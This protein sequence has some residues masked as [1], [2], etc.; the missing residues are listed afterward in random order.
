MANKECQAVREAR[1]TSQGAAPESREQS[2]LS[3][4]RAFV[5]QFR[6]E[7][8]TVHGGFVGR[9]EHMVSGHAARFHSPEELVAFIKRI[10]ATVRE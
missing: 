9:V 4:R 8:A 2:P 7:T 5:V 3:P 10:L 1:C 6:A